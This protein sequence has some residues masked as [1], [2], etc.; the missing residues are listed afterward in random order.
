MLFLVIETQTQTQH[1]L[2]CM[3]ADAAF[4]S[5]APVLASWGQ[6][7]GPR[8]VRVSLKRCCLGEAASRVQGVVRGYPLL[9]P[10]LQDST[11]FCGVSSAVAE[12][13]KAH[14]REKIP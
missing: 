6:L 11:V 12:M 1:M 2:L 9:L 5:Q 14:L 8:G 13:E 4:G 3:G 7:L 10:A